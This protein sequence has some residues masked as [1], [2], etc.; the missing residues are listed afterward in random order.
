MAAAVLVLLFSDAVGYMAP[1]LRVSFFL[2]D[3][4]HHGFELIFQ[5][6][7]PKILTKIRT[8]CPLLITDSFD[9]GVFGVGGGGNFVK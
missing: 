6:V 2:C 7:P 3:I 5:I 8:Q 1:S 9:F 4:W